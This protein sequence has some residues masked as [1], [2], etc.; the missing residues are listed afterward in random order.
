MIKKFGWS[1]DIDQRKMITLAWHKVCTPVKEGGLGLR[2]STIRDI[3]EAATHRLCLELVTSNNQRAML[4]R[5]RV[6]RSQETISYHNFFGIIEQINL[7]RNHL[8]I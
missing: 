1:D 4:M 2:S 3:N 7:S 8:P 5:T 6:S